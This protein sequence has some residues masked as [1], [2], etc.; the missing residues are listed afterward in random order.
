MGE[1]LGIKFDDVKVKHEAFTAPQDLHPKAFGLVKKGTMMGHRFTMTG[2]VDGKEKVSLIYV[3]KICN[4]IVPKPEIDN[5]IHI[6]GLPTIDVEVQNMIPVVESYVTSAAPSVDVIPQCVEAKPGYQHVLDQP[7]M[8]H[9]FLDKLHVK[10][11]FEAK[12]QD[13][14]LKSC[15]FYC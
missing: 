13:F 1:R 15:F 14:N 12:K 2:Y 6:E 8:L 10:L 5:H 9:F 11:I 7:T 4:N 3:H